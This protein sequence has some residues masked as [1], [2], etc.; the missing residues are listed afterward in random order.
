[1][2]TSEKDDK[3]S[4]SPIYIKLDELARQVFSSRTE[5]KNYPHIE[6][7]STMDAVYYFLP[8]LIRDG[9]N[10]G[11]PGEIIFLNRRYKP[12]SV[13]PSDRVRYEDY[14]CYIADFSRMAEPLDKVAHATDH[15]WFYGDANRPWLSKSDQQDYLELIKGA[16]PLLGEQ[17]LE[18]FPYIGKRGKAWSY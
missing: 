16:S 1:M 3:C 2:Q 12:L 7:L 15:A 17:E 18:I 14:Q 11:K 13:I 9:A 6:K 4:G 10:F 8:Y 5:K